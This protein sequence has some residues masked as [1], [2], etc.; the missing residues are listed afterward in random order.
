MLT[1]YW[2]TGTIGSSCR[3]YWEAER[4]PDLA[5]SGKTA[6]PDGVIV[7]PNDIL[8]PPRAWGE[9]VLNLQSWTEAP[10][11]GHFPGL[12][13]PELLAEDLR[14]FFRGRA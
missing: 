5:K 12:E 10:R 7:F 4:D 1:V 11:G 3:T 13:A 2:A 6:V 9:R 14:A 8:P